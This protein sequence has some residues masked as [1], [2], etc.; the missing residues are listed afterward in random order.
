[1]LGK[2]P[3]NE[4]FRIEIASPFCICGMFNFSVTVIQRNNCRHL[5][6]L[7]DPL[8]FHH[9]QVRWEPVPLNVLSCHHVSHLPF[10]RR[11][12]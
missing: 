7:L 11:A 2:F 5:P 1:M 10:I 6:Y 4:S 8:F 12:L 9:S 3:G